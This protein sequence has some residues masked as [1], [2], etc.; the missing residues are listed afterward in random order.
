MYGDSPWL[1]VIPHLYGSLWRWKPWSVR[2]IKPAQLA[3]GRTLIQLLTYLLTL[4]DWWWLCS[5]CDGC[6]RSV[7]AGC[8][9]SWSAG[10]SLHSSWRS[11]VT[12]T[13]SPSFDVWPPPASPRCSPTRRQSSTVVTYP[14]MFHALPSLSILVL[15]TQL[16]L[17]T[18][19]AAGGRHNISDVNKDWTCKDKDKDKGQALKPTRTRTRTMT[20]HARTW[21]WL[22]RTRTRTRTSLTVTYCK[23]QLNL[24]SPSSNNNEHKVKVHNIWDCKTHYTK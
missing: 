20:R 1:S 13:S 7:A 18:K 12:K 16:L 6:G 10:Q 2:Q 24:Q 11:P 5:C 3:F 14:S 8:T 17:Q 22:T 15:A 9:S 4:A 19:Q 21:T 23:L